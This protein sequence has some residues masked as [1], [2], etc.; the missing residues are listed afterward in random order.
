MSHVE[1]EHS[2]RG[3]SFCGESNGHA[4][5][6]LIFRFWTK[7]KKTKDC[8]LWTASIV[9]NGYGGFSLDGQ[10]RR[11]HRVAWELTFGPVPDGYQVLHKCD[12]RPCVRPD[13]LFL[14]THTDNLRDAAAKGRV[15]KPGFHWRPEKLRTHFPNGHEFTEANT[16]RYRSKAGGDYRVCRQ[17]QET[18]E[19]KAIQ[20]FPARGWRRAEPRKDRKTQLNRRENYNEK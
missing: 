15:G 10:M 12:V 20:I 3:C 18:S 4:V 19:R 7:V 11:A 6:C 8:W 13:H 1:P 16:A 14:G 9:G 17:L 5:G 2:R